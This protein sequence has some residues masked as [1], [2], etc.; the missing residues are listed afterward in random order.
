MKRIATLARMGALATLAVAVPACDNRGVNDQGFNIAWFIDP[1][2]GDDFNFDGSPQFPF[3]T[4]NRALQLVIPGDEIVLAP[5]TYSASSNKEVF[6]I[7]VKPG[8][9]LLGDPGSSGATTVISGAG[10]YT[11]QGGSQVPTPVAAAL[12]LGNGV[13]V[14]GVK[15]TAAGANGVGIVCDGT[16]PVITSSTITACGASGIRTFQGASPTITSTIL[17]SNT[18]EGVATFDT[19]SPNFRSCSMT[20]NGTDGISAQNTSVPNL[21]DASGA[22]A[23]TLTGNGAV[24][25]NNATTASTIQAVGNTWNATNQGSD[26]TGHYVA[27]LQAGPVTPGTLPANYAITNAAAAIQF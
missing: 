10:S 19:S 21:G 25:L 26:G 8:V 17:S 5:G 3:L 15:V 11:V 6:P 18:S 14:S 22:G 1:V 16:S 13:Q 9:L 24:G 20:S 27:A 23:N 4:I 2:N 7:V 12:V